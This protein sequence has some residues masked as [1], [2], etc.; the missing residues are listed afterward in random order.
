LKAL[1]TSIAQPIM[2]AL[3]LQVCLC[4]DALYLEF[5]SCFSPAEAN[6]G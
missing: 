6:R 5:V 3:G 2:A 1:W 4:V